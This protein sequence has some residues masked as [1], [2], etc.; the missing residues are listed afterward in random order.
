MPQ[1]TLDWLHTLAL[2]GAIQGFLLAFVLVTRRAN[3]TANRLLGTAMVTFSIFLVGSVY[4]AARLERVVPHFFG[5]SYPLPFLFGPLI[6]LYAVTAS[7]RERRLRRSDALHFVPFLIVVAAGL[8]VYLMSGADKL[9]LYDRLMRGDE[10]LMMSIADALKLV[11]GVAYAAATLVFLRRHG[12]RVKRSYSHV[13][14]VNLRWLL[15]L[16]GAAGGIWLLAAGMQ[17]LTAAGLL[18]VARA[19]DIVALAM[20]ALVYAIGYMGLR[21]PE[22][23]RFDTAAL[24][25]PSA[26]MQVAASAVTAEPPRYERSGLTDEEAALLKDRLLHVMETNRPWQDPELTL[27]DLADMLSTSS[28]KVSEVLNSHVG[29]TF[30][31]FVNGYR[32]REVQRRMVSE[33]TLLALAFDAGFASKST[34][35]EVFKKHTGQTPSAY[36]RAAVPQP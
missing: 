36:R 25:E 20:A 33:K 4:Y 2:L 35:N 10:P 3:H 19:D 21:Q 9:A 14:Q 22:I 30:Y 23:F 26:A 16:S 29:Q 1:V 24:P 34:F 5:V 27:A 18:R 28:H 12:G 7:D 6:Y 15:W 11:S 13:E 17:L 32:V 8:P 31:D